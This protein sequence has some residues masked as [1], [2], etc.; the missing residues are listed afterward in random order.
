MSVIEYDVIVIGAGVAGLT[1]GSWLSG[2]GLKVAL[3]TTGEPTACLSTGCIDVCA[4]NEDPLQGIAHLPAEHPFHLVSNAT[5][6]QALNDFQ[7][8]MTDMGMSYTGG[9]GKNRRILSAIGTF[10][11]TCLTPSTMQTSPQNENEKIHIITFTGLKDFYP[12]YIISRFPNASFSIYNAGVPTTMGI[13]AN[14]EDDTF[15][16]AFI[17]WLEKQN[18]RE[19]KI[20]FPA[21]LGLES[22]MSVKERI[23][24]RLERPI[25]EIPTIPPSMPGRRL[26]NG[27]KDHFRRKGGV[28]YWGWPVAG[29]E[30]TGRQIEAVIA[31][32]RGRPNSLNARA[33]ILAT[34][35]FVGGGLWAKRDTIMEKVFN[36]PVFVPGGQEVWFDQ[37]YFSVNHGIG[38]TGIAVDS[39]FRP[40]G[41]PWDNIFVCGAILAHTEALKNGC[42][43]GFAIATAQA[44]AQC[45]LEH[46]R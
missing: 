3:V 25:F 32:S 26:F 20:A 46:I 42:G 40:K 45:C 1:A 11:T 23:E 27:L 13:A 18:I 22:A 44:A 24:H 36:L 19:D 43:H 8:I 6:H 41:C 21:V 15:L 38:E 4:Q 9:L 12:G 30:K 34:G 39:S 28:I 17:L 35:S 33:F 29:V 37:D 31:E 5:I 14:F 10:K 2:Q 7:Q 16:E